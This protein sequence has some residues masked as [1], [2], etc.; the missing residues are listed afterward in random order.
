MS[1]G[2]LRSRTIDRSIP[3]AKT[4]HSGR[5]GADPGYGLARAEWEHAGADWRCAG[6]AI[7]GPESPGRSTTE[8]DRKGKTSS[9]ARVLYE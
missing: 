3:G 2:G 6:A 9:R 1:A 4:P 5:V 7:L 8:H